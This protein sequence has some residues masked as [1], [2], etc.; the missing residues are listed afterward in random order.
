MENAE[1]AKVFAELADLMELTSGNPYKVRA[2]RQAAQVIDTL[3]GRSPSSGERAGSRPAK[4]L[5]E[6]PTL[7]YRGPR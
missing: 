2:Y 5:R 1:V 7:G 3:P 4:G 6:G